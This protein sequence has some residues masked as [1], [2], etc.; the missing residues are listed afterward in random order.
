MS[1]AYTDLALMHELQPV[2]EDDVVMPVLRKRRIFER[3]DFSGH[4]VRRSEEIA[5]VLHRL[6]VQATKF[7]E[8]KARY[9]EREKRRATNLVG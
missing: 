4:G 5:A 3:D 6:E 9:L 8:A 1:T 7:E 2:V